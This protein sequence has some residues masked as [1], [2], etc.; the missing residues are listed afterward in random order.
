M[1]RDKNIDFTGGQDQ[2][3]RVRLRILLIVAAVFLVGAL[4]F[5]IILARNDFDMNLFLGTRSRE[6]ATSEQQTGEAPSETQPRSAAAAPFT[7]ENAVNILFFCADDDKLDFC[8]LAS[9]SAEENAIRVKPLTPESEYSWNGRD[10]TLRSLYE[11]VSAAAVA[12]AMQDKGVRVA[13]YVDMNETSFKQIMQTLGEVD[14]AVPRDVSY[15]VNGIT[16]TQKA[17]VQ[18]MRGDALLKYMKH[19]F[20]G[21]E[22]FRAQGEAFAAILSTHLTEENLL[23]GEEFFTSLLNRT[24]TDISVFDYANEKDAVQRF[25][26]NAPAIEVIS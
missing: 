22:R 14:V 9:F 13:R 16:Y 12:A 1:K 18:T 11:E 25:L 6:E 3:R 10:T 19:A 4:S 21:D 2:R 26:Q 7:D 17:G 5:V 23:R 8:L 24:E 20:E 15:A